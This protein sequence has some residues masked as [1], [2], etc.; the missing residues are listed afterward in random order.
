[1]NFK[2]KEDRDKFILDNMKLVTWTIKNK[3]NYYD[4]YDCTFED[5]KSIG[6]IGLI[7]AVDK[8]NESKNVEFST[9]AVSKIYGEIRVAF[10]DV[11]NGI[12]Y[13]RRFLQNKSQVDDMINIEKKTYKE[14]A[15]ELNLSEKDVADI[16]VINL[17]QLSLN[18]RVK[19]VKDDFLEYIDVITYK[20]DKEAK[21]KLYDLLN[22]LD[23]R[24]RKIVIESMVYGKTQTELATKYGV[25]QVQISRIINKS[26]EK[27]RKVA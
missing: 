16:N 5:L 7:K 21:C 27:L 25:S 23:E 14:I 6:T 18:S 9:F 22:I 20:D 3:V 1:M 2:T 19:S 10:R 11:R 24:N 26:I 15:E 12:R 4:Y 17:K 8:F 13:G